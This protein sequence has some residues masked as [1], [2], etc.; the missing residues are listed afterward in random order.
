MRPMK[1]TRSTNE[2][3]TRD[4]HIML[5][6]PQFVLCPISHSRRSST[7]AL[8]KSAFCSSTQQT[9]FSI[10]WMLHLQGLIY[11]H[12]ICVWWVN[13]VYL[14]AYRPL[15]RPRSSEDL[16]ISIHERS[17]TAYSPYIVEW[18]KS[19]YRAISFCI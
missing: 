14:R 18:E 13:T 19:T 4:D 15:V 12:T 11:V 17:T 5:I 9:T 8:Q 7:L 10:V 2:E 16:P 6:Y 1:P 3:L